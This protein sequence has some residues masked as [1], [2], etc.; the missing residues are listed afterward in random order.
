VD[1]HKALHRSCIVCGDGNPRGMKLRFRLAE[2]GSV[3]AEVPCREP[4]QG[5]AGV[6]HGG[7]ISAILD[8]AMTH[9]LFARGTTAV[10]GELTVRFV[11]PVAVNR[12]ATVR[13]RVTGAWSPL[14]KTAAELE[15]DGRIVA[16][17]KAKFVER[18][19]QGD[20][21]WR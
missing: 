1:R 8:G 12:N 15:Q 13:A 18:S 19:N 20:D 7:V 2:D 3:V 4:W 5:Y 16:R 11:L 14:Y 6:V 17:A 10:T 9:C 21:R